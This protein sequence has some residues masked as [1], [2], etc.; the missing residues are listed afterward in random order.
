MEQHIENLQGPYIWPDMQQLEQN[1]WKIVSKRRMRYVVIITFFINHSA[2]LVGAVINKL[3]S[4]VIE[5]H[6]RIIAVG[7]YT[8]IVPYLHYAQRNTGAELVML[9]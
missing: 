5:S 4:W 8:V 3:I 9:G 2:A 1:K 7:L 6:Y